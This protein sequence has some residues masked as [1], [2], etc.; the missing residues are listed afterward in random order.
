MVGTRETSPHDAL[1][2]NSKNANMVGKGALFTRKCGSLR[3]LE[4]DFVVI[5]R[6]IYQ[7]LLRESKLFMPS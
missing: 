2:I 6:N 4:F 1:S 3:V 7:K 5:V